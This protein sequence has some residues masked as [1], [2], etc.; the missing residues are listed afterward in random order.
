MQ[1]LSTDEVTDAVLSASRALVAVAARSLSVVDEE[2][3]LP[4]YRVLVVLSARASAGM[5]ELSA[6]LGCSASTATRLCDRLV[7]RGLIDR[8][9]RPSNRRIVDVQVTRLG[10]RLV[11]RVTLRRRE[12]VGAIVGRLEPAQREP[13]VE[14]F[15]AFAAATGD[16]SS[17]GVNHIGL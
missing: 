13:L 8:D 15:R 11:D 16:V 2:V 3:T 1:Q 10:R 4:Q 7:A 6:E 14:A 17:V 12:E 5:G 9:H